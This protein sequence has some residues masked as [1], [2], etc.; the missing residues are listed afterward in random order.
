[1]KR[2]FI[3]GL[4][5][6]PLLSTIVFAE[7]SMI[8]YMSRQSGSWELWT[9]NP[10][11][12]NCS[13]LISI[14][15]SGA[16]GLSYSPDASKIAFASNRSGAWEIWLVNSDG[17]GLVQVTHDGARWYDVGN[18]APTWADNQNILYSSPRINVGQ[19]E[20]IRIKIDGTEEQQLTNLSDTHYSFGS[21][22]F[23]PDKSQITCDRGIPYN[24]THGDI[25]VTTY[26][27]FLN[28]RVVSTTGDWYFNPVWSSNNLLAFANYYRGI[29]VVHP[30]GSQL[31]NISEASNSSDNSPRFSPDGNRIAF[32]SNESGASNI[33]VMDIDGSNRRQITSIQ[34]GNVIAYPDW[35][36]Q[37]ESTQPLS[38]NLQNN[39]ETEN[40]ILQSDNINSASNFEPLSSSHTGTM[41]NMPVVQHV[42][43]S[44][45]FPSDRIKDILHHFDQGGSVEMEQTMVATKE[46]LY[47][48]PIINGIIV[49]IDSR[50][51]LIAPKDEFQSI[52]TAYST[53]IELQQTN[54][55]Q[56][57]DLAISGDVLSGSV[58]AIY[59]GS[60]GIL[61]FING[62]NDEAPQEQE[63]SSSS[64]SGIIG[65]LGGLINQAATATKQALHNTGISPRAAV[66][67][68]VMATAGV[69]LDD[70]ENTLTPI[71]NETKDIFEA[72][73]QIS[74]S[75]KSLRAGAMDISGANVIVAQDALNMP[76]QFEQ[77]STGINSLSGKIEGIRNNMSQAVDI[78]NKLQE[79][80]Q[81]NTL[82]SLSETILNGD[83]KLGDLSSKLSSISSNYQGM[84]S[85]I[86][87][88]SSDLT[89]N[90]TSFLEEKINSKIG[91]VEVFKSSLVEM[92][93]TFLKTLKIPNPLLMNFDYIN[94][95]IDNSKTNIGSDYLASIISAEHAEASAES[96]IVENSTNLFKNLSAYQEIV[97]ERPFL[98]SMDVGGALANFTKGKELL[99]SGQKMASFASIASAFKEL[100]ILDHRANKRNTITLVIVGLVAVAL[101][102]LF[103]FTKSKK[104]VVRQA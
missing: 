100:E 102:A 82:S 84:N 40:N 26:P 29:F 7:N 77:L 96:L 17:T 63:A 85:R 27:D 45:S 46:H 18:Y 99:N 13:R 69:S 39:V 90:S 8:S 71:R 91:S 72:G 42:E 79:V 14:G 53:K 3:I 88:N 94:N 44:A 103:F 34:S 61:N 35:G 28:Q 60:D 67:A 87:S 68:A 20:I 38:V 31:I 59:K 33:W 25:I 80:T 57:N 92:N 1:M 5:L 86:S 6:L 41:H 22:H 50:S 95:Q 58:F 62:L 51:D 89:N 76:A 49:P 97:R 101:V 16:S 73:S 10:N 93:D 65:T 30:D 55:D 43:F 81:Y 21:V 54:I 64:G 48:I 23:S 19:R 78:L 47:L 98:G 52:M 4:I 66:N 56:L 32:I 37:S 11:N 70:V 15:G 104:A 36:G 24:G 2:M 9:V 74:S 83:R 75:A 12:N